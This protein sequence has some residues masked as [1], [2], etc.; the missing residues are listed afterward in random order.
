MNDSTTV[1]LS[2]R[3]DRNE[4]R[5][6]AEADVSLFTT[7]SLREAEVLVIVRDLKENAY[8]VAVDLTEEW[9]NLEPLQVTSPMGVD[10]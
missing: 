1:K 7:N 10:R 3:T 6:T 2:R 4:V 8:H 5:V 9:E